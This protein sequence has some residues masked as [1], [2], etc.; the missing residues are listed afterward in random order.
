MRTRFYLKSTLTALFTL[1]FLSCANTV[2]TNA[3][4][5]IDSAVDV[6]VSRA[7][8]YSPENSSSSTQSATTNKDTAKVT[9]IQG[10]PFDFSPI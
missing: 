10:S 7:Q 2:G 4:D 5:E 1:F 8:G 9:D 6:Y 3:S